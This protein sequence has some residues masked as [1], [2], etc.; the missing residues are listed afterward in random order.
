LST[1]SD[2]WEFQIEEVQMNSILE[3]IIALELEMFLAVPTEGSCSCQEDPEAFQLHRRAQFSIWSEDT[4]QS[5][6]NDLYRAKKN[7]INLMT[8][9]YARMDNL[10]PA[11]NRNPQIAQIVKIQSRW[12][13]EMVEKYPHLMAGARHLSDTDSPMHGTSFETYLSAELETYSDDTLALLHR[14]LTEYAK[15]GINGSEKIFAYLVK[16]LGYDSIETA[17]QAQKQRSR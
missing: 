17:D 8:I 6:L 13:K 16:Q 11:E 14:D 4:L 1:K 12:Q 3:K 7:A 5:Y 9:K 2:A 15:A 10:L